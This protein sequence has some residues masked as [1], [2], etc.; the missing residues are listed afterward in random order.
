MPVGNEKVLVVI[1]I[2]GIGAIRARQSG[3]RNYAVLAVRDGQIAALRACRDHDEACEP[4][5]LG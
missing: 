5:G 2:P 3:D 1:H 4:A